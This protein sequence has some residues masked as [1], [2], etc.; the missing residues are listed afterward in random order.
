MPSSTMPSSTMPSSTMPSSTMA[1]V[2]ALGLSHYPPLCMLDQNMTMPLRWTL[3]DPDIP[4]A[5]K[6][7]ANWPA[8]MRAEW[9]DDQGTTAAA[10]H[11]TALV[12]GFDK[13][14][15]KLDEFDPDVIVMWGDDQY[16]NFKED[17]IPP[18]AVLAYDDLEVRPWDHA[19]ASSA[20]AGKP[21]IWGEDSSTA[22]TI[23][24]MPEV[25]H[26]LA[27]EL[28]SRGV[29]VAYGY[30][31]LHHPSLSHAFLNAILFLDYHRRGFPY[32]VV[33]FPLN[34]YGRHVVSRKG[35]LARF[36]D[37]TRPDPPS[38]PPSRFM[39]VG[40][41]TAAILQESP[42]RVALI[43]SSS[44]SHAFLCDKTWRLRPDTESDERLYQAMVE[45]DFD[46][47][48]ATP[49]S[50]VED[51]GQ[52]EVLNWWPLMGAIEA[53]GLEHTWSEMVTTDVFN[54]NK[55]FATF[56]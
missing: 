20:M 45:G 48:R 54:S 22:F 16:E 56:E 5:E 8:R 51:A 36:G 47:W 10:E 11:R 13:I 7:P 31:P 18:Y 49:L 23:R 27:G 43:A 6:D 38:P 50:D 33:A 3:D 39:T 12:A 46:R 41:E 14:R 35:F 30:K 2:L 44:W 26:H 9:G 55:V 25:G 37:Q 40:A 28:L 29:D 17:C 1:E 34:C 53:L 52:H 42:W 24:G 15:A 32:P 4:A 19:Q 21:N